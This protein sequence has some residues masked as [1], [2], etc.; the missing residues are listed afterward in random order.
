MYLETPRYYRQFVKYEFAVEY[1]LT[2]KKEL[3]GD[4]VLIN[5]F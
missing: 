3:E 1:L 4:W 2:F 5:V